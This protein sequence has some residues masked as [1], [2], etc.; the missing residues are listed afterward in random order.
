MD[1]S[2]QEQIVRGKIPGVLI[3]GAGATGFHAG[4]A[5]IGAGCPYLEIW[6]FD[7]I[8]ESNLN[9]QLYGRENIGEYKAV[10][11]AKLLERIKP[12]EDQE[13]VPVTKEMDPY[14]VDYDTFCK[15]NIIINAADNLYFH[16]ML[17]KKLQMMNKETGQR[18]FYISPRMSSFDMEVQTFVGGYDNPWEIFLTKEEWMEIDRE[19]SG[20]TSG[21][22]TF[23]PA[24]VTTS[25]VLAGFVVQEVFNW[26]NSEPTHLWFRMDIESGKIEMNE[27]RA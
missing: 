16:G 12:G 20:C 14:G 5:L 1:M 3:I 11:L 26:V 8:E 24:V 27:V 25:M 6:D 22:P 9:R 2:R 19:R 17:W 15:T 18:W 4:H 23:S 7:V 13:I 10:A 21:T